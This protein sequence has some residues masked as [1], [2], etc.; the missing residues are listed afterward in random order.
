MHAYKKYLKTMALVWAGA[1]MFFIAAFAL[2]LNP[3]IREKNRLFVETAN[4]QKLYDGAADAA[5]EDTRKKFTSELETLKSKMNDYAIDSEDSANMTL[6]ISRIAA[7]K[8]VS[9]FTIK[10]SDQQQSGQTES[11]YLRENRINITFNAN[12][13]Q[14]AALLNTLERHRPIIFVD[15]FRI[16]RSNEDNRVDMEL[17]IFVRKRPEG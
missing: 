4:K 10:A 3:Q 14:F 16:A 12:F 13:R 9:S 6:D 8:Q 11:K 1:L 5:R 2:L 7:A 15:T 17:S